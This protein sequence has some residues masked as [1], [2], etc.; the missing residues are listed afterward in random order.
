MRSAACR[1]FSL[2][3]L[4]I[5]IA[6]QPGWKPEDIA[7]LWALEELWID[8]RIELETDHFLEIKPDGTFAVAKRSGDTRGVYVLKGDKITF[9]SPDRKWF[10]LSWMAVRSKDQLIL[11]GKGDYSHVISESGNP[12]GLLNTKL[13]FN[14][15]DQIPDYQAFEDE[16]TGE[17]QLYKIRGKG[18]VTTID[19]TR[20]ILSPGRYSIS[21]DDGINE[22]GRV[23]INTRY[24]KLYF[25]GQ[26]TAWDIKVF[27]PELRLSN[28]SIGLEYSLRKE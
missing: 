19:N 14:K 18:N 22:S 2:A 21:G 20:F 26:E 16:V 10:Y 4:S 28:K 7:G 23:I 11:S 25:E 5:L 17:W 1:F 13:V 24:Q 27:G 9:E 12:I 6:C 15:I 3:L 8:G